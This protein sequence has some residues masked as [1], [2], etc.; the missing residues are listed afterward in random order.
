MTRDDVDDGQAIGRIP[1]QR[2]FTEG[3]LVRA[4]PIRFED[5]AAG[6]WVTGRL[7]V[8]RSRPDDPWSF[9]MVWISDGTADEPVVVDSST[10]QHVPGHIPDQRL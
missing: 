3:D 9:D 10:L 5:S 2:G 7:R 4:Q 6:D 8:L 1:A